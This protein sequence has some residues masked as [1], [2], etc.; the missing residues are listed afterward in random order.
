V[1]NV[2]WR[3]SRPRYEGVLVVDGIEFAKLRRD[4]GKTQV[5]IATLL[6]VSPKAI[7]S[8]EQG[9][10]KIPAH[11]ERQLLFLT[12]LRQPCAETTTPCWEQRKCES[13]V[14]QQCITWELGAGHL[15]WFINGTACMGRV[16]ES[17][18]EKMRLCRN[19]EVFR[20]L[21]PA[22]DQVDS[23]AFH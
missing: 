13:G 11:T 16:Q 22:I 23:G 19:C 15:C 20:S 18:K 8:F 21:V 6:G 2:G 4:L 9:W 17:W 14:R 3:N 7:Q 12:Y 10:R 1:V 5:H